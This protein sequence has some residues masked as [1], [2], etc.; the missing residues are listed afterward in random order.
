M[1][2]EPSAGQEP[3]TLVNPK[4]FVPKLQLAGTQA[5]SL[6]MVSSAESLC[7]VRPARTCWIR[8][9]WH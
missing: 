6:R 9:V 3:A 1:N 4:P 5:M 2:T 7:V 8:L